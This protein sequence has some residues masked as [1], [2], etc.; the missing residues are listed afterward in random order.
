MEYFKQEKN[1]NNVEAILA[2]LTN[3]NLPPESIDLAS[4]VDAYHE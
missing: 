1:I 3:P 2:T 4:M